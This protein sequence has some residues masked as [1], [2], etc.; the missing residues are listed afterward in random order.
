MNTINHL[1]EYESEYEDYEEEI[2]EDIEEGPEKG[3][4]LIP[5]VH[6]NPQSIVT[7]RRSHLRKRVAEKDKAEPVLDT[8]LSELPPV[9]ALRQALLYKYGSLRSVWRAIDTNGSGALSFTEFV[10]GITK[11]NIDW[12]KITKLKE[13]RQLFKLFDTDGS[14]D[15]SLVEFLGFPDVEED[16]QP[17]YD[18]MS[19]NM[20]WKRYVNKVKL[21]P[22]TCARPSKWKSMPP[23]HYELTTKHNPAMYDMIKAKAKLPMDQLQREN[24]SVLSKI[25]DQG[26]R[27]GESIRRMQEKRDD[28]KEVANTLLDVT[29]GTKEDRDCER[30]AQAKEEAKKKFNALSR[31]VDKRKAVLAHN[32]YENQ[33]LSAEYP[34]SSKNKLPLDFLK[35]LFDEK[36]VDP[37]ER[38]LRE[39]AKKHK[40]GLLDADSIMDSFKKYDTDGSGEIDKQEF[41]ELVRDLLLVGKAKH[42]D[43]AESVVDQFWVQADTERAGAIGFEGFLVWFYYS[44]VY[45]SLKGRE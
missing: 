18:A 1:G 35:D 17:N 5:V 24:R 41:R 40:I 31:T 36:M 44:G 37:D 34:T 15:I 14:G 13:M 33:L 10:D 23:L 7:E 4:L 6:R 2:E 16:E 22:L 27:I 25:E 32:L 3:G 28:I 30:L 45:Q 19:T 20:M 39:I 43:L 9:Q 21:T 38:K 29:V 26:R 8:A 42:C 11:S 12:K